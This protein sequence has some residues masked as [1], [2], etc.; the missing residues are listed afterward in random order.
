MSDKSLFGQLD[1]GA[2]IVALCDGEIRPLFGTTVKGPNLP[3]SSLLIERHEVR[4]TDWH[5]VVFPDQVLMLH[6]RRSA[7]EIGDDAGFRSVIRARG[8]VTI[9][10]R[11]CEQRFRWTTPAAVLAVR[12]SDAALE[13]AAE[14]TPYARASAPEDCAVQDLRLSS[15]MYTLERERLSGYP[16]GRMFLEGIEQALAAIIVRYEG[17]VVARLRSATVYKG[18]LTPY[19]IRRVTE[20]IQKHIEKEITLNELA[21]NVGL[22]AS[23]FC[24]LFHKTSGKTP[25]E[26]IQHCRIQHA[27]A[28]LANQ[29]NSILDVALASGFKTHQHFSRIFRRHVG[30][31]PSTYRGQL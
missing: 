6:L 7:M 10:R 14:E 8:S 23:H 3:P 21:R 12:I 13:Q 22:S 1:M 31:S 11:A 4:S 28:L 5:T 15:L 26:F 29:S 17:V 2:R 24:S 30:I 25:H 19:R 18:G 20:F 16:S 27:K 9:E